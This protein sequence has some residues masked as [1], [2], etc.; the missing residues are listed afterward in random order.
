MIASSLSDNVT[1][2]IVG[3]VVCG[4]THLKGYNTYARPAAASQQGGVSPPD[5]DNTV[6]V[7]AT[8]GAVEVVDSVVSV[9]GVAPRYIAE[10]GDVVVGRVAEV[11]GS[12]WMIDIRGHQHAAMALSNVTQPGGVLRKRGREDELTMRRLFSENDLI[13]AEVQRVNHDGVVA[14][15]TRSAQK[16]GRLGG[17]GQVA[18]VTPGLVRRVKK[19]FHAFPFGVS[20]IMGVNG[21]IWMYATTA[22]SLEVTGGDDGADEESDGDDVMSPGR[23][24]AAVLDDPVEQR[25]AAARAR[26]CLAV[27]NAAGMAIDPESIEAAFKASV[28][29]GLP[30]ADVMLPTSASVIVA[31]ARAVR[32]GHVSTMRRR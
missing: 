9:R 8:S 11:L 1:V 31:A 13:C 19:H 14:L 24:R 12:K 27:L 30:V 10:V 16:Y 25:M 6:I 32:E 21:A 2:R 3:E 22:Q 29:R 20:M 4:S 15:H 17:D 18:Y 7:A 23:R 26:N 5:G 28:A